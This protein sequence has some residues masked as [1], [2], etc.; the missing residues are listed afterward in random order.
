MLVFEQEHAEL[1]ATR[2]LPHIDVIVAIDIRHL[3][4]R[5]NSLQISIVTRQGNIIAARVIFIDVKSGG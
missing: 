4:L 3:V 5:E 2:R 1:T